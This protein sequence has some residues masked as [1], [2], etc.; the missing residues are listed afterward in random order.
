MYGA[1]EGHSK[2][3]LAKAFG[4]DIVQRW[5]LG[6][7]DRPPAMTEDHVY[8]HG[9][10][11]KYATLKYVPNSESLQDTIDR[12]IPIWNSH[13]LHD[14]RAGRN[15][16]IVGHRNSIRGILKHI[17]NLPMA[18]VQKLSIPNGIPLVYK[19]DRDLQPITHREALEVT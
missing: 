10:D 1:L 17:D 12:T 15:V 3:G 16:L 13:I 19:F 2:P 7:L 4:A 6:L 8:W 9:R 14:L 11:S 18:D 5:R